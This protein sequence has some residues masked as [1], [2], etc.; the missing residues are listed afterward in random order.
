MPTQCKRRSSFFCAMGEIVC[1]ERVCVE[2]F[3]ESGKFDHCAIVPHKDSLALVVVFFAV[4]Q[5]FFELLG[6]SLQLVFYLNS[7]T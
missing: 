2:P 6:Y 3:W 7:N 5:W 1:H 4:M